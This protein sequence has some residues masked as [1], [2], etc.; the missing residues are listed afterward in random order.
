MVAN[1]DSRQFGV[2]RMVGGRYEAPGLPASTASELFHYERLV[3]AV[4]HELYLRANP[5]RKR[6]PKGFDKVFALRIVDVQD[7]SVQP[8]LER[9]EEGLSQSRIP[10]PDWFDES[11][12]LIND[13]LRS[14][15]SP[16]GHLPTGFPVQALKD[17]THF[18]R[19][20]GNTER[21][22]LSS[23]DE[24]IPAVVNRESRKRLVALADLHSIEVE[25]VVVGQVTGLRSEPQEFDFRLPDKKIKGK[26]Q[27]PATWEQLRDFQGFGDRA[28]L[29]ALSALASCQLD[30][31]IIR[32]E[33]VYSLEGALPA[34]WA[35]RVAELAALQRGW[36]DEDAPEI[37]SSSLDA[38]ET[39]LLALVDEGVIRPG[40]FPTPEG[41]VQLEW[42]TPTFDIQVRTTD[43]DMYEV[44]VMHLDGGEDVEF[45]VAF[46]D[47]DDLLDELRGLL[48]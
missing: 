23:R 9:V 4:A 10:M 17:F 41:E 37:S 40:I 14:I 28:P 43:L 6:V 35:D 38:I 47:L 29:V 36:L 11:R 31:E 7:G 20:L 5:R 2:F 8:V 48:E 25:Q 26:Y 33:D 15:S 22:E 42:V 21:F 12:R 18:G 1:E 39:L 45:T 30:G 46:A 3:K 19:T 27:E 32:I 44:D 24:S 13:A 16:G 34:P